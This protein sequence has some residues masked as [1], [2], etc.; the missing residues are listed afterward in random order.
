MSPRTWL[1]F[2]LHQDWRACVLAA[3]L[4]CEFTGWSSTSSLRGAERRSGA[5]AN[6]FRLPSPHEF[7]GRPAHGV[8]AGLGLRCREGEGKL[9][10]GKCLGPVEVPSSTGAITN[11]LF[12]LVLPD[13]EVEQEADDGGGTIL[14]LQ[15]SPWERHARVCC[16]VALHDSE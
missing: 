1:L 12:S 11:S 6:V 3:P 5:Q 7:P 15:G 4:P 2:S 10:S 16:Y 13:G 8:R 9:T 14:G